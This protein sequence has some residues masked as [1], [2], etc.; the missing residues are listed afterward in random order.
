MLP[1]LAGCVVGAYLGRL[2]PG[3]LPR[4]CSGLRLIAFAIAGG[5]LAW[6]YYKASAATLRSS[7]TEGSAPK[8][9]LS[10]VP[11]FMLLAVPILIPRFATSV[12]AYFGSYVERLGPKL[13]LFGLIA[14]GHLVLQSL[15]KPER[16]QRLDDSMERH[17]RKILALIAFS[18][19]LFFLITGL[20]DFHIFGNW[21]DLSRFTTAQYSL[22]Q[23]EFFL[24]RLHTQSGNKTLEFV[25]D[26]F[27]PIKL[28]VTPFFLV[29]RTA[30]V[31][32]VFKTVAMG[33][34][35]IS[36]FLLARTRLAAIESL[37]LTVAYLLIPTAVSQNYTGFHPV[38]FATFLVPF[39]IYFFEKR[40]F[41]WFMTFMVLCCGLKE[42]VPFIMLLFAGLA[43]LER[44]SKKWTIAPAVVNLLWIV[45]VFAVL[46]PNFRAAD[47][48]MVVRY[49]Y[50]RSI[51]GLVFEVFR[52][53]SVLLG[54]LALVQ[55]QEFL[56]YL[57][58]PFFFLLPFGSLYSL[59][60]L[61]PT[62]VVAGLMNWEVPITFHHGILPSSLFAPATAFT[63]SGLARNRN[64]P[65]SL[66][67]S[68]L[69]LLVALCQ[70]PVWWG[71][72][73]MTKDTYFEAQKHAL[74]L[75]PPHV[76][77]TAPRYMLPHL[78]SRNEVFFL[79]ERALQS[80]GADYVIVD[81]EKPTAFWE[82]PVIEMVLETG[83]LPGFQRVW[84][85]GPMHVFVRKR[86]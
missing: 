47:N 36:F 74:E 71:A 78:A 21:H 20:W 54:Q 23:G 58:A 48:M 33:L 13:L 77:A 27:A 17:W 84:H 80:D 49:P 40:R 42:N 65:L 7:L 18:Y 35:A 55:K 25:G 37:M 68:A 83:S 64:R 31:F 8:L 2:F 44:R 70:I 30:A 41:G 56:F 14:V 5:A 32:L 61:L 51:S 6:G 76:P 53:P 38:V 57:F 11:A 26:H 81:T 72:S 10:F 69:I 15:S 46:F 39:A 9:A 75:V 50:I 86:D 63:I 73:K 29:F 60:G 24:S 16:L 67:L 52:N 66:A 22:S 12:A 34:A 45:L 1:V 4:E 3:I 79:N 19:I 59:M 85:H 62:V 43:F 82:T 28:I